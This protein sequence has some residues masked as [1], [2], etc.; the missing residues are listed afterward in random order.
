MDGS[1]LDYF[2]TPEKDGLNRNGMVEA[3]RL[4]EEVAKGARGRS[5]VSLVL[6]LF[7][8]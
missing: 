2:P 6:L 3:F 5:S 4:P 1:H 7:N 8:V